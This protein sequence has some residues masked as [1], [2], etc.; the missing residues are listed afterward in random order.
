MGSHCAPL[1]RRRKRQSLTMASRR[2][3]GV[4]TEQQVN[5]RCHDRVARVAT[6]RTPRRA[7]RTWRTRQRRPH[8]L[9]RHTRAR[10]THI[11]TTPRYHG[12]AVPGTN[13]HRV[14]AVPCHPSL[15]AC[16]HSW[17]MGTLARTQASLISGGRGSRQPLWHGLLWR[18]QC[19]ECSCACAGG[20]AWT[21][22]RLVP[23]QRIA[24]GASLLQYPKA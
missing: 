15:A 13:I 2:H 8:E 3:C 1:V 19:A 23:E 12:T 17:G 24:H 20:K 7:R 22:G 11:T 14:K 9:A 6:G 16:T 5:A 10:H 21:A 4:T 18:S